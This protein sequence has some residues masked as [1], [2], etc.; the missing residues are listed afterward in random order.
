MTPPDP[1]ARFALRVISALRTQR[2]DAVPVSLGEELSCLAPERATGVL[3]R[4]HGISPQELRQV[5]ITLG[6]VIPDVP[7]YRLDAPVG[8]GGN[9]VVWRGEHLASAAVVAIKI[10]RSTSPLD[11]VRFLREAKTA[12]EVR[13]ARIVSVLDV[14]V[15]GGLR[16]LAL[17][18]Q[19]GGDAHDLAK[20]RGGTLAPMQALRVVTQAAQGLAALH[21]VGLVHRDCN[22]GNIFLD[23]SGG[24]RLG[25]LG[26][27]RRLDEQVTQTGVALGTPGYLSPEQALGDEV[28]GRSDIFSMGATLFALLVGQA[29]FAADTPL[30]SVTAAAAGSVPDPRT[31]GIDCDSDIAAIVRRATARNASARYA[32][33]QEFVADCEAVLA[34]KRPVIALR[35]RG[36]H[37]AVVKRVGGDRSWSVMWPLLVAGIIIAV[38]CLALGRWAGLWFSAPDR[39]D[40]FAA[41]EARQDPTLD[42]WRWYGEHFLHGSAADEARTVLA[43]ADQLPALRAAQQNTERQLLTEQNSALSEQRA[44]LS[45]QIDEKRT[46]LAALQT[47]YEQL[48]IAVSTIE[49][50]ATENERR[51]ATVISAMID[52]ARHTAP[53]GC[54]VLLECQRLARLIILDPADPQRILVAH[55]DGLDTSDD[56]GVTWQRQDPMPFTPPGGRGYTV[57]PFANVRRAMWSGDR[58]Y[59]DAATRSTNLTGLLSTDHGRTFRNIPVAPFLH[60]HESVNVL[61]TGSIMLPN[62]HLIA[63]AYSPDHLVRSVDDGQTWTVTRLSQ[64]IEAVLFDE[65]G[66]LMLVGRNGVS[67]NDGRTWSE[68]Q[69]Y[70]SSNW[71]SVSRVMW[72]QQGLI[73]YGYGIRFFTRS[74]LG[75][76]LTTENHGF[77]LGVVRLPTNPLW[78]YAFSESYGLIHSIDGGKK[79][80]RA[81]PALQAATAAAERPDWVPLAIT[82]ATPPRLIYQGSDGMIRRIIID[83]DHAAFFPELIRP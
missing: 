68:G 35:R 8:R 3:M 19:P 76:I 55:Q 4:E 1:K 24:A 26:L 65:R 36:G 75:G 29:P 61:G 71:G 43:L 40:A 53:P 52:R 78:V 58:L 60:E 30:A 70:G 83:D 59:L 73:E 69:G 17:E 33:A 81:A 12:T 56:Y 27:V 57:S 6:V 13:H 79:W 15:V 51:R 22:P 45:A 21:A 50:S 42:G 39:R 49:K 16:Y 38:G 23:A 2:P 31:C 37:R 82:T 64:P 5:L 41:A 10:S 63:G 9:G 67:R 25:D 54:E 62:G 28:D 46:A 74:G 11:D 47:E 34:G 66:A 72:D 7:G 20:Q 14:G 80:L 48:T 18:F 77:I 32:N 44:A